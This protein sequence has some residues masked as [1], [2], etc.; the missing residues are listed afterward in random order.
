MKLLL[1]VLGAGCGVAGENFAPPPPTGPRLTVVLPVA[2]TVVRDGD[3]VEV[4]I[5]G[6]PDVVRFKGVDTPELATADRFAQ[7]ALD[8]TQTHIGTEIDLEFDGLCP[9]PPLVLCRDGYGR[10]LA[11]IRLASGGDLGAELLAL[12]LARVYIFQGEDFDRKE[13]YLDIE[14]QARAA[15]LGVWGP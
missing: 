10:L 5:D 7:E 9:E 12:G 13:L 1:A 6:A 3:T 2:V 14:A 8:Y 15:G 11:Y 4:A